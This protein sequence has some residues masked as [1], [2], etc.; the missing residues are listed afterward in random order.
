MLTEVFLVFMILLTAGGVAWL[1]YHLYNREKDD[2]MSAIKVLVD[3]ENTKIEEVTGK[4]ESQ[5]E[6]LEKS[7]ESLKEKVLR[8][9]AEET[10]GAPTYHDIF[11]RPGHG[12]P[13]VNLEVLKE[14]V[15]LGGMTA[16]ELD[17]DTGVK[18]C[19]RTEG[20][21]TPKCIEFP[22]SDGDTVLQGIGSSN[23]LRVKGDVDFDQLVIPPVSSGANPRP[24]SLAWDAAG[25]LQLYQGTGGWESVPTGT[26]GSDRIRVIDDAD[27]TGANLADGS[28]FVRR[29][30]GGYTLEVKE[31]AGIFV[32]M[33]IVDAAAPPTTTTTMTMTTAT[34]AET[35]TDP[36]T[37]TTTTTAPTT[38]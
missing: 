28:V 29:K 23:K 1:S 8:L 24:G 36:T 16:R 26:G 25:G 2:R 9:R 11:D 5:S 18:L 4:V 33:P 20:D 13:T 31:S 3:A 38:P 22:S 27:V 32:R 34:P 30:N 35:T 12:L 37:T 6:D 19:K 10:D 15:L 17:S 14:L 21:E 7:V